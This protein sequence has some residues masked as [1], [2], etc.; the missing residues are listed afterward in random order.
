[1][2]TE[3]TVPNAKRLLWA[4]FMAI[5]A[6]GVGF[7][8]RGG[9]IAN[10][11]W[12]AAFN[13]TDSMIG[14][15]G[16]A[17][18]SGFCFGIIIGGVIVDKIGYGKL[19][20]V[21]LLGHILSAFVTFGA[22]DAK[23]AYD[24][25]YW[26]M[27]IFAFANGT[28]EAVANPL[29]ATIFPKQRT[30]YLN[31]L[32][33]S[34]PLG[35]VV[36]AFASGLLGNGIFGIPGLG[37]SWQ[38]QLSFYLV[39]TIA[40]AIMF[41]GQ[42]FPKSEAAEKGASF[43]E[44]FKDV[45]ILGAAVAVYL[46]SLFLGSPMV[47][48]NPNIGWVIGGILLIA[49]GIITR[50]SLGSFLLF[51]LFITH[52]LVGA[53]ELGTDAWIE[54]I[55]G[56][57]FTADQGK[58]LFIWSS[59]IMF[60][61][62]FCAHFI[63]SKLGFSPI[64]ILMTSALLAFGGLQ[65]AA[66][67]QSFGIALLALGIYALGKTFFWPTM[68]AVVGDR[69]P[70][71][72]AVAMSIMGGI[73]MLSAGLIGG[74]GLGYAKDRFT[75]ESLSTTAPAVYAANKSTTESKFLFLAPVTAVAG[76][77]LE[78]AKKA[79]EKGTAD[80]GKALFIWTSAIMF[81]LRFCA[82]FIETKLGLSP[83]GILV[84]SALLAFGGLQLA[85][86]MDSF[87]IA[88]IALG[89][90]ALGKTFFWPTMLAVVGDRF[91]RSGA[92]A[93]SIMGGIGMLSAGLIGGPGLGYAKDRFTAESLQKDAPAAYA[94]AKA[95]SESKF[96]FLAPVTAVAGDKLEAA[97]KAGEKG[98]A[99]QKAIVAAN[100]AGDRATLKADSFIP[101]TMAAIYLLLLFYFKSLGGY[102]ALKI[103]EQV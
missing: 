18:F 6:A 76:D 33:A 85:S 87:P 83:I 55:T 57:L 39:P 89:I 15:I 27:F 100:Q 12:K 26:G 40:Y 88:L 42:S 31:I 80:Q 99:D 62:R 58:A 19:I 79:G 13:F 49:V 101:L 37:L 54:A 72:G 63:E 102:R 43:T 44:M 10:G 28:L 94:S 66:G 25:L 5:L 68:L 96:L 14:A 30:H 51:V 61:L 32:H 38:Y 34:W 82:H 91:P 7:A 97:K 64:G 75:S 17:G 41:M 53:V 73:G 16:G 60:G 71:S 69:F 59:A 46:V 36:G 48:N 70:R 81:G 4:G 86:G 78:A 23:N 67:M 24:F 21:A 35:M 90:Y 22:S 56:N 52:A 9:I 92:V 93:M 95:G 77:K 45:G 11:D 103:E 47:F 20:A 84:T 3:T 29:V 50:F 98:S 1:M 8:L 74:P 65:L 2:S